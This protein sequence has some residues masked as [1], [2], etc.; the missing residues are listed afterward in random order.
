MLK[1]STH[2]I[3]DSLRVHSAV[4]STISMPSCFWFLQEFTHFKFNADT[5]CIAF[6]LHLYP[7]PHGWPEHPEG[8]AFRAL[9][10]VRAFE[11]F[12]TSRTIHRCLQISLLLMLLKINS[13]CFFLFLDTVTMLVEPG[14]CSH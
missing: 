5:T 3:E 2:R 1:I 8:R 7:I 9:H 12:S 4:Q 10:E 14:K 13:F 11:S 6:S